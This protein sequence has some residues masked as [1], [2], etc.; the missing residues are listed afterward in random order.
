MNNINKLSTMKNVSVIPLFILVLFFLLLSGCAFD[1]N[2]AANDEDIELRVKKTIAQILIEKPKWSKPMYEIT[3]EALL[4][5]DAARITT[6]EK[7]G[8]II[9]NEVDLTISDS[10]MEMISLVITFLVNR[11]QA[12]IP[13]DKKISAVIMLTW[14]NDI[15]KHYYVSDSVIILDGFNYPLI[16]E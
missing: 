6:I 2:K 9:I 7:L 1:L 11:L 5:I 16:Q 10:D 15:A 14:I 3:S 13:E 4:N 12:Q 8:T